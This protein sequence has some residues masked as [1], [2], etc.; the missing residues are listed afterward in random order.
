MC[1]GR[2]G[3]EKGRREWEEKKRGEEAGKGTFP[4]ALGLQS[5]THSLPHSLPHSLISLSLPSLRPIAKYEAWFKPVV[6][7]AR[8]AVHVLGL[9]ANADRASKVSF[10]DVVKQVSELPEDDPAFVSPKVCV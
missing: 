5:H 9:V 2:S 4:H 3:G 8:L 6:K 1:I 10:A 7:T